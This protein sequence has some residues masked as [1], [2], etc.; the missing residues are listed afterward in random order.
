MTNKVPF[1]NKLYYQVIIGVALGICVGFL[2]PH[3]GAQMKPLGTAFI[4]IVKM[5]IPPVIFLTVAHGIGSIS[6]ATKLKK[7]G[8]TAIGYF[9]VLS[10]CAL[11]FG[12]LAGNL[13]EPGTG[14]NID[15]HT[16]K[17]EAAGDDLFNA[18]KSKADLHADKGIAEHFMAI[19]PKTLFSP[20]TEGNI[21]QLLFVAILF[22]L[23]L[24]K[25]GAPA[26][27]VVQG[28]DRLI[29]IIFKMVDMLMRLAPIGAFGAIA[30]T[31]GKYGVASVMNLAY[32]IFTFYLTSA[33][34]II[35]V[36]GGICKYHGLR[37]WPLICYFKSEI[38]LVLA[39]SSSEP[40]LPALLKKLRQ[41]GVSETAAG[42]IVPMG[43]SFNLDGINIYMTLA[44]LFIAQALNIDL[45]IMQQLSI[46]LVA[47]LSSKG[48]AGV[49]GAGF[50]VLA[51]TL[52]SIDGAIP[53]TGMLLI[54]GIDR[55]MSE[56]RAL[57]SFISN[58]VITV[59]IAKA[60]NELDLAHFERAKL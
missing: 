41:L 53:V 19:I 2:F 14:M 50:I 43:Y 5:I 1:Y 37:L 36:I 17:A 18:K 3:Y 11:V 10:T 25:V 24:M 55:F 16:L 59:V 38:L 29:Q 12:L 21:L 28:M 47:I 9:L 56:C 35:I 60:S 23:A 6:D 34:F 49:T 58:A 13:L 8:G 54:M 15:I 27:G 20:F 33:I 22:G 42:L 46:L 39:T 48:A 52:S 32:L 30:Y 40:A 45:T 7:V 26:K 57:T 44:A 4:N 51:S 31:I